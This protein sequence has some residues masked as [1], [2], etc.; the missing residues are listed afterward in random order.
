M[1]PGRA[2]SV[3]LCG[4]I[5]KD[6]RADVCMSRYAV[7]MAIARAVTVGPIRTYAVHLPATDTK[8]MVD[9]FTQCAVGKIIPVSSHMQVQRNTVRYTSA[10]HKRA[11]LKAV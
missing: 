11:S 4:R 1:P 5:S 2:D 10:I 3:T 8:T 9:A 7:S 6:T